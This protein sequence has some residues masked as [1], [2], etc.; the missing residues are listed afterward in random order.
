LPL[1]VPPQCEAATCLSID[2]ACTSH[3]PTRTA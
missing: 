1:R 2:R 3:A